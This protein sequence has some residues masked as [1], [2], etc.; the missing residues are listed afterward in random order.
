MQ[1]L[2]PII[3]VPVVPNEDGICCYLNA[4]QLNISAKSSENVWKILK[5]CNG[6]NSL[7]NI[8]YKSG[9]DEKTVTE[10]V[11]ELIE[12]DVL[13]DSRQ[14][15]KH[16]HRI[17]SY[18]GNYL[19]NRTQKEI[20][21]YTYSSHNIIKEG[22]EYSYKI[23]T[24]SELI[25]LLSVRR[26]CR[27]FSNKPLSI[28]QIGNIC[29][30]A[31]SVTNHTVP[32]GGAL[33]PLKIFVLV[34]ENQIGLS[35]GYYEYDYVHEILIQFSNTIDRE[36]L[37]Y[38]FN[39]ENMPFGSSV[40]IIISADITR[41]PYKYSN[42]GYRLTLME[43]GHAAENL[44]LYC[45][46]QGL[47]CCEL[48]GIL[49]EP[50]RMELNLLDTD[51]YPLLGIAIGYK[52]MD[53]KEEI[54]KLKFVESFI[55][56]NSHIIG[57]KLN[58][59]DETPDF[60]SS[61]AVY[62]DTSGNCQYSGA[63]SPCYEDALFKATIEAYERWKSGDERVDYTG[64]A[65]NLSSWIHPKEL[66]PLAKEQII[67]TGLTE[68]TESIRISWVRG[69]NYENRDVMIPTDIVYYGQK[70][71]GTDRLYYSNSSGVA[72]H[73]L[74]DEARKRALTELIERDAIMNN[75]FKKES[76]FRLTSLPLHCKK[77]VD[78]WISKGR[79]MFFLEM[80]S[81]YGEVIE[82][83]I[84]SDTFP[85]FV[86][87]AAATLAV[88]EI[89]TIFVKSM[90]EAE[91]N[92]L[93][94]LNMKTSSMPKEILTPVDHGRYYYIKENALTIKWLIEG[95]DKKDIALAQDIDVLELYKS[96][97]TITVELSSPTDCIKV[98]RVLSPDLLPIN[99]GL[100]TAH[101]TH[102]RVKGKVNQDI[103]SM[104]HYFA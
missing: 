98:V 8:I 27:N 78:Y 70:K 49:D 52:G 88:E 53:N 93:I 32:S 21:E 99:F 28:N 82:C 10:I 6:Y 56:N 30:S 34:E 71:E 103:L 31:Y 55:E 84:F 75:W 69:V 77:H 85:C 48:G 51:I 11:D 62:K 1:S 59:F 29:H 87:G 73:F 96:L 5:Y 35:I 25:N 36:K 92:L 42:R 57:V 72:A 14:Q 58:T 24:E 94:A 4:V 64:A 45:T 12:L 83:V 54:N 2:H 79:E 20:D 3:V 40:Q 101:Y 18:P 67:A 65:E 47:G 102:K 100:Q 19:Y 46:E 74:Y 86:C 66:I 80:P 41:Q 39:Q 44:C 68:F 76:P 9:L 15:Y 16:F 81:E 60:Y 33:Y 26:S 7:E 43:A 91:N 37:K 22:S 95:S 63:V 13:S 90:Q 38:C 89:E 23:D 61:Y 17:S 97:R 104:P 50:M